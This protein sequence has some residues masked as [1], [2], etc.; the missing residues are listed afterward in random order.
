[1]PLTRSFH[2]M[3]TVESCLEVMATSPDDIAE[4]KKRCRGLKQIDILQVYKLFVG[5]NHIDRLLDANDY[6]LFKDY[7]NSLPLPDYF[8]D[9]LEDLNR[10]YFVAE[11]KKFRSALKEWG[12]RT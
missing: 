6:G 4:I 3:V 7:Y 5:T 10:N 2:M 12:T 9:D 11:E 1:M 8:A